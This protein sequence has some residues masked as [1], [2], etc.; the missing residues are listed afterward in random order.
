ML[1]VNRQDENKPALLDYAIN[2]AANDVA[3]DGF[4]KYAWKDLSSD[5]EDRFSIYPDYNAID[6]DKAM[7]F[8]TAQT[9]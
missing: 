2:Y 7:E 5:L 4:I 8:L 6:A 9:T 1:R 3:A